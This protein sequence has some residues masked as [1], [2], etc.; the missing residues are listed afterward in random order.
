MNRYNYPIYTII[1]LFFSTALALS[2]LP[3]VTNYSLNLHLFLKEQQLSAETRITVSNSTDSTVTALPFLLYRLLE[4]T[5]IQDNFGKPLEFSQNIVSFSDERTL[6]CNSITIHLAIPLKPKE[7]IT[8]SIKYTG[9]MLGYTEV[10][11]YVHDRIDEEFTL[12]RP[13]AFAYPM[14]S[15]PSYESLSNAYQ[16]LY[17]FHCEV[18]VPKG[19]IVAGGGLLK[20]A[21]AQND[22]TIFVYESKIPT[23]RIDIAIAKFITIEDK[24]KKLF[25][26]ALPADSSGAV[27]VLKGMRDVIRFYSSQFGAVPNYQGY[28]AIQIPDGWGSQASDYYFLQSSAAFRDSTKLTEVYHEIGHTWNVKAKPSV[29]RCRYFD[30]AFASYFEA[31]ALKSFQGNQDYLTEMEHSRAIFTKW[32][33][34]DKKYSDT[35]ISDYGKNEIGQLSYSKGAWSLYVLHQVLGDTVFNT[36][37]HQFLSVFAGKE[38]DFKDFQAIAERVSNIKLNIFFNEWIY[39]TESSHLLIENIPIQSIVE[40]YR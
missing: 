23:W 33:T 38:C 13:D 14:L 31:L 16:H 28:T 12:L 40:R 36:L 4:V 24:P 10:M 18:S 1:L 35:P 21:T 6:Q 7:S 37:I 26:Y 9:S 20:S 15:F 32:A 11:Q 27:R 2:S 19:Y 29:A 22:T 39:G 34:R 8:L 17:T 3:S 5:S 30:E 25:V